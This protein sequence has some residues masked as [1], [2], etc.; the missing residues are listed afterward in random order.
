M[1]RILKIMLFLLSV[2]TQYQV[3]AQEWTLAECLNY[4]TEN[5]E[6]IIAT[7]KQTIVASLDEKTNK[8]GLI[9]E[10]NL[11][12]SL[13]YYWQI[14]VQVFP[15][16][17][18][19][20][21]G[22]SLP[23]RMGT[24]W[25]SNVGLS[26][27]WDIINPEKWSAIKLSKLQEQLA[28][29]KASS[30]KQI[31]FK[32]IRMAF[33]QIQLLQQNVEIS[34]ER[35]ENYQ[36]IHS[37]IEKKL[38]NGLLD[39]I[40]Y[41]QSLSIL[42][43]LK[44]NHLEQKKEYN[45][46]LLSLK[47]WMGYPLEKPLTL[48]H[49][50]LPLQPTGADFKPEDLPGYSEQLLELEIVN[51]NLQTTKSNLYPKLSLVGGYSKLG[52]GRRFDFITKSPW[53]ASG[54]VGLELNIPILSVGEMFYQPQKQKALIASQKAEFENFTQEKEQEFLQKK[55]AVDTKRKIVVS[56]EIQLSLAQENVTLT[57]QKI[58]NGI[59][60]MIELK[61]TQQDMNEALETL[62]EAK[63]SLLN[64][65]IELEYLQSR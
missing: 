38:Q 31:L 17:L 4:A 24:P 59:I 28:T 41:N 40:A 58:K 20:Q 13:D 18:L 33:Y 56:K 50:T 26:A 19:G 12:G 60:D 44:N 32:N 61:Q 39:K 64:D 45:Q 46:T 2:F 5:N 52:F 37:L 25:M 23:V 51:K 35:L 53:F 16:E 9:P 8:A 6:K 22:E 47:F 10:I 34:N 21:P 54:Y 65:V 7:R 63:M 49:E 1:N 11:H 42:E 48:A 57:Y 15:G 36:E 27:S 3:K 62:N 43:S 29:E 30:F 55:L 14:P